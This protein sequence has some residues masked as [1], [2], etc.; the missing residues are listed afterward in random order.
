[1]ITINMN[2]A[3]LCRLE[4]QDRTR[5]GALPERK[6]TGRTTAGST[7][8]LDTRGTVPRPQAAPPTPEH[9]RG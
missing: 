3:A 4:Q 5:H 1:M 8:P 9:T 2:N 6:A 7:G